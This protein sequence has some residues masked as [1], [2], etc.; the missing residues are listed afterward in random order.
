MLSIWQPAFQCSL[1][2]DIQLAAWVR[3]GRFQPVEAGLQC[4]CR[5]R[6][7][8]TAGFKVELI[9]AAEKEQSLNFIA[10]GGQQFTALMGF[11]RHAELMLDQGLKALGPRFEAEAVFA[12]AHRCRVLI[13][14][15]VKDPGAH[16]TSLGVECSSVLVK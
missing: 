7:H 5:A 11:R 15:A 1:K 3:Q 14:Q 9:G 8:Q 16:R 13:G 10:T 4:R 2:V 6:F 12:K